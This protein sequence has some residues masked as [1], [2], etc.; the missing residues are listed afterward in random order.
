VAPKDEALAGW[1]QRQAK[2]RARVQDAITVEK[3]ARGG[4][5][6]P[7]LAR[8]DLGQRPRDELPAI[9]AEYD[10]EQLTLVGQRPVRVLLARGSPDFHGAIFAGRGEPLTIRAEANLVDRAGVSAQRVPLIAGFGVSDLNHVIRARRGE[11]TAIAGE[12]RQRVA[13]A[14]VGQRVELPAGCRV[15]DLCFSLTERLL[16][17][18]GHHQALPS[19][20]KAALRASGAKEAQRGEVKAVAPGRWSTSQTCTS[21]ARHIARCRPF[22]LKARKRLLAPGRRAVGPAW[23]VDTFQRRVPWSPALASKPFPTKARPGGAV[24]EAKEATRRPVLACHTARVAGPVPGEA[25][26]PVLASQARPAAGPALAEASSSESGLNARL[27]TKQPSWRR[28][29]PP[30]RYGRSKP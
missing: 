14:R 13:A 20:L 16:T 28:P 10:V 11:V 15:A 24:G 7:D 12:G 18:H 1:P 2:H 25:S 29:R 23:L 6:V 5:P 3:S 4:V 9:G 19:G 21:S 17:P 30:P 27:V 26:S 8:E 22:G